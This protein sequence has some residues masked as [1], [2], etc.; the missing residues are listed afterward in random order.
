MSHVVGI[1]IVQDAA[2]QF[3]I[4]HPQL[5]M[6]EFSAGEMNNS[7]EE[8]VC[9]A[10]SSFDS[11]KH[12]VFIGTGITF[13][14]GDVFDFMSM[15]NDQRL[16]C[17]NKGSQNPTQTNSL[18]DRIY[19][20]ASLIAIEPSRRRDYVTLLGS[21]LNPGGSILLITIEKR[22]VIK[23]GAKSSGPPFSV[24]EVQVRDLYEGQEWVDSISLLEER[25][26][27]VTNGDKERWEAR[28]VSEAY[29]LV[30]LIRK[31]SND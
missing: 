20:R 31:K 26:E 27:I 2:E 18:F 11:A 25:N 4:E 5:S 19:D 9:D 15:S 29:E 23:E 12:G 7:C 6:T 3:V 28:G 14:I 17:I 10:V 16:N 22:K 21:M 1:D 8:R 13:L 30:F 24:D